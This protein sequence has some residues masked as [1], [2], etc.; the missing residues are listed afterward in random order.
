MVEV[1]YF[2]EQTVEQGWSRN[3]LALQLKS[4]LHAHAGKAVPNFSRTLPS[5]QSDLAQQTLRDPQ[6]GRGTARVESGSR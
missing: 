3:V 5:L 2:I 1:R 4:N 6:A